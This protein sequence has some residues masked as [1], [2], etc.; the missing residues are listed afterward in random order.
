[1]QPPAASAQ[2]RRRVR[3][4]SVTPISSPVALRDGGGAPLGRDEHL[5]GIA[6]GMAD[7]EERFFREAGPGLEDALDRLIA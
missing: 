7:G 5:A 4:T 3:V 1:M 2:A 6:S